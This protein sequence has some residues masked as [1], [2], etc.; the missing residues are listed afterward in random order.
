MSDIQTVINF[1]YRLLNTNISFFP[2]S[3]TIWQYLLTLFI[4]GI[5]VS[6]F[7]NIFS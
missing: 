4:F 2:Y 7:K 6:F 5:V 3:F 1:C